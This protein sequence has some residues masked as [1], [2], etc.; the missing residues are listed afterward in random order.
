MG[1]GSIVLVPFDKKGGPLAMA[2]TGVFTFAFLLLF[3]M[4]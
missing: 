3:F 2:C 4:P 1:G